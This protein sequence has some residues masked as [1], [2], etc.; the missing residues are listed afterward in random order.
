[1][2][3]QLLHAAWAASIVLAALLAER[4][5]VEGRGG[6]MV[7]GV[8][9]AGLALGLPRELWD[10]SPWGPQKGPAPPLTVENYIAWLTDP[11]RLSKL[12]DLAG[13][14]VGAVLFLALL[15]ATFMLIDYMRGWK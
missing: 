2:V 11:G 9:L 1:M 8:F 6:L 13:Y 12:V 14:S 5:Y 15:G 7:G 3:D 10:Q 4:G